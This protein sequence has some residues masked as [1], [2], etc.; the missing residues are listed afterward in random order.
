MQNKG[1]SNKYVGR[2]FYLF[3]EL[4]LKTKKEDPLSIRLIL[5]ISLL[6]CRAPLLRP[7]NL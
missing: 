2:Y 1:I 4:G 3:K 6:T 7:H 5:A